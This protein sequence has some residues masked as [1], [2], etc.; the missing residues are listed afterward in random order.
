MRSPFPGMDPYL[1]SRWG[2]VHVRLCASI[3]AALQR[4]LPRGL[5]ARSEEQVVLEDETGDPVYLFRPDTIVVQTGKAPKSRASGGQAL[6]DEIEIDFSLAETTD[7]WVQIID[8][9][10]GNRVITAIEILSPANKDAGRANERYIKKLSQFMAAGV[11]F[12]EIDL[13]RSS[14]SRLF[15]NEGN[16]APE[17]QTPYAVCIWRATN[18]SKIALIPIALRDPLPTISIPC[19]PND[20]EVPLALQPLIDQVYIDGGHD[21]IDYRK[22]PREPLSAEDAVWAGELIAAAR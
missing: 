22:P 15:V 13:L 11:N 12:V 8:T 20:A 16:T 7:R 17:Y 5:R 1:E 6:L 2:D 10:A 19:R 18:G 9:T 4:S 3:S 21:D 14:R